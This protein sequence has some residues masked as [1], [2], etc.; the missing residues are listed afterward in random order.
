MS[1]QLL[2]ELHKAG[3]D[4][5]RAWPLRELNVPVIYEA[6]A[7]SPA[8]CSL[9]PATATGAERG[10]NQGRRRWRECAAARPS[11]VD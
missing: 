6:S 8:G 9:R 11:H 1:E 10:R 2:F 4:T 5:D 7:A 3:F